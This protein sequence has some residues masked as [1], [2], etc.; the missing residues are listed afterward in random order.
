MQKQKLVRSLNVFV[1]KIHVQVPYTED[2]LMTL[3]FCES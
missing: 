2:D 3:A 1:P